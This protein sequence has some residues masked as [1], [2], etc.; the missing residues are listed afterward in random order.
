ME[1]NRTEQLEALKILAEFNDRLLKNLPTIIQ[2]LS[3]KRQDDTEKYLKNI[4]DSINW[5]ISV[6][7]STL[8]II[9]DGKERLNKEEFNQKVMALSSALSS[10]ADSEIASALQ[11]LV[12]CF[13]SLGDAAREVI[14]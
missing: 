1:N 6:T 14:Q 13:V 9:N 2:E 7:A 3:G 10:N 12:P 8:N 5:E 4:I 11:D